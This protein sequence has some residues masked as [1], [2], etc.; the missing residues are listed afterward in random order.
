MLAACGCERNKKEFL[1]TPQYGSNKKRRQK[2]ENEDKEAVQMAYSSHQTLQERKDMPHDC[3]DTRKRAARQGLSAPEPGIAAGRLACQP[4]RRASGDLSH[5]GTTR[6]PTQ[7]R[8]HRLLADRP[9]PLP[10]PHA[11]SRLR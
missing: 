10:A 1:G 2:G 5:V 11:A 7:Y 6:T 4:D 9:A 8:D 3:Y